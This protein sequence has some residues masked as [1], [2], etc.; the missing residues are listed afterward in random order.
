MSNILPNSRTRGKSHHQYILASRLG[1]SSVGGATTGTPPTQL[2]LPVAARD[3][4]PSQLSVQTLM[5]SVQAPC[6]IAYIYI[7]AHVK[8]P[9]VHVRFRW[10]LGTLKHPACAVGWVARFCRSWLSPGKATRISHGR[11]LI[12]TIQL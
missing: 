7:L 3:F 5:V 9:V 2:P 8:D 6:A 11:N 12:G 10:I 1:C 4:S